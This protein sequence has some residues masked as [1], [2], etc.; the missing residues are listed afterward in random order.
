[1]CKEN[2]TTIVWMDKSGKHELKKL[3]KKSNIK[4]RQKEEFKNVIDTDIAVDA[5]QQSE[6]I[7]IFGEINKSKSGIKGDNNSCNAKLINT[8]NLNKNNDLLN[9]TH[10]SF[11]PWNKSEKPVTI[12]KGT[13]HKE[14]TKT[15]SIVD[16]I[17]EKMDKNLG[18]SQS[19]CKTSVY[20]QAQNLTGNTNSW[21]RDKSTM[22]HLSQHIAQ[23]NFNNSYFED[24]NKTL[25][26]NPQRSNTIIFDKDASP[27]VSKPV[28]QHPSPVAQI[29]AKEIEG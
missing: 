2:I 8:E 12:V 26:K 22:P 17:A 11:S 13:P 20:S 19:D 1:M 28:K 23:T 16:L 24:I 15:K 27:Q 4:N 21:Q 7:P 10:K 3:K 14:P 6:K 5:H 25:P 18:V 29:L 9:D